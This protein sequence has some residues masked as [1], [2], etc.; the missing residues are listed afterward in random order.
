MAHRYVVRDGTALPEPR[1]RK[2]GNN[3]GV[4][5]VVLR[6]LESIDLSESYRI[7][8]HCSHVRTTRNASMKPRRVADD[9]PQVTFEGAPWES[10]VGK[11]ALFATQRAMITVTYED[12]H[13]EEQ[14][15][16]PRISRS[17]NF[18]GSRPGRLTFSAGA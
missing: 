15:A 8:G 17:S 7:T 12:G 9:S 6:S 10:P 14:L 1:F 2:V 18:I 13:V 5:S 16:H 3:H 11:R 4:H